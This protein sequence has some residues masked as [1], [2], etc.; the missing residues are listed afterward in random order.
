MKDVPLP[1]QDIRKRV[2]DVVR[3]A[4]FGIGEADVDERVREGAGGAPRHSSEGI[5]I[6]NRERGIECSLKLRSRGTPI[7]S[8]Q[9]TCAKAGGLDM[10]A[11]ATNGRPVFW[12]GE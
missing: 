11:S 7:A 12:S 1:C 3:E 9:W 2:T 6:T 5:S 10:I 8:A 4:L